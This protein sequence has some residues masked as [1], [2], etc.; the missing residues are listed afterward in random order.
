MAEADV[1]H[2]KQKVSDLRGQLSHHGQKLC[3]SCGQLLY[4]NLLDTFNKIVLNLDSNFI[5]LEEFIFWPLTTG[6]N[7]LS[8]SGSTL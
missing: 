6:R 8:L 3:P 1:I 4:V 7:S 5:F 2:L